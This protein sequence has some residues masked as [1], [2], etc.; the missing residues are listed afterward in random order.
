MIFLEAFARAAILY[1]QRVAHQNSSGQRLSY[2]QLWNASERI[3]ASIGDRQRAGALGRAQPIAVIGHKEPLMLAAFI[4]CSKSGHP[5]VPLDDSLPLERINRILEQLDNTLIVLIGTRIDPA[6]LKGQVLAAEQLPA[7]GADDDDASITGETATAGHAGAA[8]AAKCD[9]T[10][11][12]ICPSPK[13]ATVSRQP[14]S[15]DS[16][17]RLSDPHRWVSGDDLFYI[18]FTS[19]STGEPKGV[20]ISANCHDSFLPWACSLAGT[21]PLT[22]LPESKDNRQLSTIV[23]KNN[24]RHPATVSAAEPLPTASPV[25]PLTYL[26]QAPFSF[27]LSVFEVSMALATGG[28]LYSLT[29]QTLASFSELCTALAQSQVSVWVSTPSFAEMCLKDRS[30][31]ATVVPQVRTF[32]FCGEILLAAT[33]AELYQRFVKARVINT[34][35]PTEAT[36]AVTDVLI[37]KAQSTANAPL[38]VGRPKPG[39]EIHIRDEAGRDQPTGQPGEIVI[40][41]DSVALG[42]FRQPGLTAEKFAC[43]TIMTANGKERQRTYRTGDSG[44]LDATGMVH[45]KGRLDF[46]VKLNGYRI[47][48]GDIEQHLMQ[49][50]EVER[51]VVLAASGQDGKITHLIACVIS[52]RSD[53]SAPSLTNLQRAQA[54]RAQLSQT[55]PAYMLPRLFRFFDSFP[56]TGNGKVDRTALSRIIEA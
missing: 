35:G 53:T 55:L 21:R 3:S 42:Y 38:P 56:L 37:T 19:G 17:L 48:L 2:R 5:Y 22:S 11:P 20:Q 8:Q 12:D 29:N 32:L 23:P 16:L 4:G 54:L 50:K 44:F 26:N 10:A 24:R 1:P 13:D 6:A 28:T 40:V 30:F 47:E 31:D 52:A 34:Y 7:L 27:D 9:F 39:T 51:A 18:L 49:L 46:Q 45:Y 43:E 15:G 25:E 14:A 33:A 41:G 36:V